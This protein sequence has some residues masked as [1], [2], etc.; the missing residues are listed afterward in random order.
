MEKPFAKQAAFTPASDV[1]SVSTAQKCHPFQMVIRDVPISVG[2]GVGTG[3]G[4][5]VGLGVGIT[6]LNF[7]V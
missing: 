4:T 5:G 1:E 3:V 2:V 7:C 6:R